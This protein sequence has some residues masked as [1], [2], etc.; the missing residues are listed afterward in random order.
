MLLNMTLPFIEQLSL[1][2][3]HEHE[4]YMCSDIKSCIHTKLMINETHQFIS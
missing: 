3:V 1:T 2:S 4:I